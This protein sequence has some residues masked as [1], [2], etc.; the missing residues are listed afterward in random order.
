MGKDLFSEEILPLLPSGEKKQSEILKCLFCQD[1]FAVRNLQSFIDQVLKTP[2]AWT[3]NE[4][5]KG[6]AASV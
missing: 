6:A 2:R 1:H 3:G 4:S 5:T